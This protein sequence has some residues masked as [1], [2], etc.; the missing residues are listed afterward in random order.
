MDTHFCTIHKVSFEYHDKKQDDG[1]ISV[2]YSHRNA[3][4]TYCNEPRAKAS[5]ASQSSQ[6]TPPTKSYGK[7][8]EEQQTIV[9]LSAQKQA[10]ELV[11]LLLSQGVI[12]RPDENTLV[13]KVTK[14][15]DHFVE[16][17]RK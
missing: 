7:S 3:D 13:E 6:P 4:G 14:Y 9:R 5:T 17:A 10:I 2:W 12:Q 11:A 16:D 1:S 8:P 15:T